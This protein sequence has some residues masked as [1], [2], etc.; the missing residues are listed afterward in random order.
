MVRRIK[1]SNRGCPLSIIRTKWQ[2]TNPNLTILVSFPDS[3]AFGDSTTAKQDRLL[4]DLIAAETTRE[5]AVT[6]DTHKSQARAWQRYI[7][8]I[9]SVGLRHDPLLDSLTRS[10]QNVFICA[11]AMAMRQGRFSRSSHDKLA[12][13]TITNTISNVCSTFRGKGRPNPSKDKDLQPSFLIS[14]LYRAFKKEDPNEVQK[15]SVPPCVIL[16]IAQL[17]ATK[18]QRA[19]GQL[20]VISFFFAMRSREYIKVLRAEFG[21]TK[22]LR[23]KNLR[24]IQDRRIL[25]HNSPHLDLATAF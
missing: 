18:V 23:P 19:V 14:R 15:N 12:K 22:L 20:A 16:T 17:Q 8:Y 1:E 25:N 13:D 2:R 7:E 11:F 3:S 21:R 6:R 24:F 9:Q 5:G 4:A 10:K